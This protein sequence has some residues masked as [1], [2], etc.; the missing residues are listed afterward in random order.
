MYRT[1]HSSRR[2]ETTHMSISR[3][4]DKQI[5]FIHR[6]EHYSVTR[7]NILLT[8][9]TTWT[10]LENIMLT[11]RDEAQTVTCYMSP[12]IENIQNGQIHGNR[13]QITVAS[14]DLGADE[15]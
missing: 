7:K 13:K 12:C 5:G 2:V 10:N 4:V 11:E 9:V 8:H 1:T 6:M 14:T 3:Y 15:V